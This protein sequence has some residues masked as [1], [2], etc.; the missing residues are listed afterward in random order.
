MLW[1][2]RWDVSGLPCL[3]G[4]WVEAYKTLWNKECGI[5]TVMRFSMSIVSKLKRQRR[6][7]KLTKSGVKIIETFLDFT[8][9]KSL[10]MTVKRTSCRMSDYWVRRS[11]WHRLFMIARLT[12]R[13]LV[14]DIRRWF[15]V[16]FSLV[17]ERSALELAAIKTKYI[18]NALATLSTVPCTSSPIKTL[19]KE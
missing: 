4:H 6:T 7:C 14:M 16:R 8:T 5:I 17:K 13:S 2:S 10:P 18:L 11:A 9:A 3:V 15:S 1:L 19:C 12:S